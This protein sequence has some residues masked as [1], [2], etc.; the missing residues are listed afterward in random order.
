MVPPKFRPAAYDSEGQ[1]FF[2]FCNAGSPCLAIAWTGAGPFFAAPWTAIAAFFAPFAM[3]LGI[4]T[5]P[6]K[7]FLSSP[8]ASAWP[9]CCPP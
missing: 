9:F 4:M 6:A 8:W 7:P 5:P 3:G 1:F 2:F